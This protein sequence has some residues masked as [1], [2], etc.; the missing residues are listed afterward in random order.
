MNESIVMEVL[1]NEVPLDE[2][3]WCCTGGT[4][5]P[6]DA[7]YVNVSGFFTDGTCDICGGVGY[8]LTGA[9]QA[10]IDLVKRHT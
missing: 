10:I 5:D 2:E 7:R 9:G 3:C 8:T 6:R 1:N 4:V